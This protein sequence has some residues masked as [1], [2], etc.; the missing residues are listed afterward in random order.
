MS[1]QD[2]IFR[3][4]RRN[5]SEGEND[6]PKHLRTYDEVFP[7]N[8]NISVANGLDWPLSHAIRELIVN[9]LDEDP[10]A[11]VEKQDTVWIL[12][13]NKVRAKNTKGLCRDSFVYS[14]DGTKLKDRMTGGK[15]GYGLKDAIVFLLKYQIEYEACSN[16]GFYKAFLSSSREG[17]IEIGYN[18]IP[19]LDHNGAIQRIYLGENSSISMVDLDAAVEEAKSQCLALRKDIIGQKSYVVEDQGTELGTLY[20]DPNKRHCEELFVH[21]VSFKFSKTKQG[22]Y[23]KRPMFTYNLNMEKNS[24]RSRDR[25]KLPDGWFVAMQALL[26]KAPSE[27]WGLLEKAK[28]DT[29]FGPLTYELEHQWVREWINKIVGL[30]VIQAKAEE[31]RRVRELERLEVER[32]HQEQR[33]N[34][35]QQLSQESIN[36]DEEELPPALRPNNPAL[37]RAQDELK[38]GEIEIARLVKSTSAISSSFKPSVWIWSGESRTD[39]T[40]EFFEITSIKDK[41][42]NQHPCYKEYMLMTRNGI[43]NRHFL[44]VRLLLKILFVTGVNNVR[45][46][47]MP[48][49]IS[50]LVSFSK[51]DLTLYVDF[52]SIN[53]T[54]KSDLVRRSFA[55][56]ATGPFVPSG[57]STELAVADLARLTLDWVSD[58]VPRQECKINQ[59]YKPENPRQFCPM[60]VATEWDTKEGGISAFNIQLAKGIAN[61]G[62]DVF[63][64]ILGD[65]IAEV[66]RQTEEWQKY[67][68][69]MKKESELVRQDRVFLID[70]SQYRGSYYPVMGGHEYRVTHLI[71]HA[72]ITGKQ[73]SQIHKLKQ[74]EHT[75]LWQ[76]NHVIPSSV[77]PLKEEGTNQ[78]R[79]EKASLKE[80]LIIN[81][82]MA[83][84]HL[85]SVGRDMYEHFADINGID[86]TKHK[87]IVLPFNP[88]FYNSPTTR[89]AFGKTLNVLFLG[90]TDNVYLSK[91]LDIAIRACSTLE[92]DPSLKFLKIVLKIRGIP[93]DQSYQRSFC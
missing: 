3:A 46:K 13:N 15:F 89:N 29:T 73:V 72:H 43:E 1:V 48:K 32:K 45:I 42:Y 39:T 58:E 53:E 69:E 35:V 67:L 30:R 16:H 76:F 90:R 84:D 78:E 11:I 51:A 56:L 22:T 31:D 81:L 24:L 20:Y 60:L 21:G 55:D 74:F 83:A 52:E 14:S 70:A 12:T 65:P 92:A 8:T 34:L 85:W 41:K 61:E 66:K 4:K 64:L 79:E 37:E 49:E 80:E 5:S 9:C 77:D 6:P 38:H 91:G 50:G 17:D 82:N 23:G 28:G 63:V 68:E 71:G 59:Y 40:V 93:K 27:I 62:Y 47:P 7:T 87:Q 54:N 18:K 88:L 26:K 2:P 57:L 10:G 44:I 19:V 75:K 86:S 36:A 25:D 33:Q